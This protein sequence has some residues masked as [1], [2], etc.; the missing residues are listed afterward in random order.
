MQDKFRHKTISQTSGRSF[1]PY[2]VPAESLSSRKYLRR[3]GTLLRGRRIAQE[4]AQRHRH[5]TV[6][7]PFAA[8]RLPR[9]DAQPR[10]E[11]KFANWAATLLS[12]VREKRWLETLACRCGVPDFNSGKAVRRCKHKIRIQNLELS[13]QIVTRQALSSTMRKVRQPR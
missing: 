7:D 5:S 8:W 2:A 1:K 12:L 3:T 11:R 9:Y 13:A 4:C 6:N 10:V